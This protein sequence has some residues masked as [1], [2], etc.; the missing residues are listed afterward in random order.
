MSDRIW[1]GSQYR[2]REPLLNPIFAYGKARNNG[3]G[4]AVCGGY[5]YRGEA[6]KE[7]TNIAPAEI[8]GLRSAPNW[9][10][11]VK[12]AH[13]PPRVVACGRSSDP[14][15]AIKS[16]DYVGYLAA[17]IEELGLEKLITIVRD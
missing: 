14:A 15:E 8:D 10:G 6:I 1:G 13:T 7:V 5:V 2:Q 9:Q 3:P 11:R 17:F 12:A 4:L 16:A